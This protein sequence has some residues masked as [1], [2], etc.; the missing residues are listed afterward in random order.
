[1]ARFAAFCAVGIAVNRASADIDRA[2]IERYLADLQAEWAGRQRHNDHIGQL[3]S[4]LNAIRQHRWDDSL[5]A[6]ALV[7]TDDYPK[8]SEQVP[9][10]LV[11][12]GHGPDRT[13]R[14]PGPLRKPGIRVGHHNPDPLRPA[15]QRRATPATP[16]ALVEGRHRTALPTC[17]TSTT[18]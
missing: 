7:F 8:R 12:T 4:F 18:R 5:P 17:A 13:P 15:G 11:R 6:S 16:T 2:V 3:S 14:Q 1:M 9:R 10:A